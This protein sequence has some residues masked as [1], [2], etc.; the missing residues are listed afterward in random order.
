MNTEHTPQLG[1]LRFVPYGV[2]LLSVVRPDGVSVAS[3]LCPDADNESQEAY[4]ALFASAPDL[5]D[6]NARLKKANAKLVEA[7]LMLEGMGDFIQLHTDIYNI[8]LDKVG[9]AIALA[10]KDS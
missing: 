9:A 7:C 3:V 1:P 5:A 10:E 6:E 2:G 8:E 4:A